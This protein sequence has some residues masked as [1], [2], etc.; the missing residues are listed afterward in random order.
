M[1]QVMPEHLSQVVI[2]IEIL[3]DINNISVEEVTGMLRVVEQR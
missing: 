1:L 2:S 3:L